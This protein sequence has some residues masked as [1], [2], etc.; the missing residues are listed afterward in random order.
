MI[1]NSS[2][3]GQSE[4]GDGTY[5]ASQKRKEACEYMDTNNGSI[6]SPTRNRCAAYREDCVTVGNQ[7][8]RNNA[9]LPKL[10]IPVSS[11]TTQEDMPQSPR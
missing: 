4:P 5:L 7:R 11:V 6:T 2:K 9:I 3:S 10:Q 8:A 1:L